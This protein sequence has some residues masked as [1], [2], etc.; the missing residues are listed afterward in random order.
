MPRTLTLLHRQ[1][2]P[3]HVSAVGFLLGFPGI[4]CG[5]ADEP[6][7]LPAAIEPGRRAWSGSAGP[8]GGGAE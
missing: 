1:P 3:G 2:Q 8:R 6:A 5:S 7:R 4:G